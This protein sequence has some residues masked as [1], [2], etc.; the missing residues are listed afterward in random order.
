MAHL[1][2][3]ELNDFVQHWNTHCMRANRLTGTPS[4]TPSDLYDM[5]SSYSMFN[6]PIRIC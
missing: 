2:E 3:A 6:I 5:P 4:A 1:V